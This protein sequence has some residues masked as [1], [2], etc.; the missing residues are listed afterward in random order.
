MAF[1]VRGQIRSR[2]AMLAWDAG[3]LDGDAFAVQQAQDDAAW[4]TGEVVGPVGGPYVTKNYFAEALSAAIFLQEV[5]F[6]RE[7]EL[8]WSGDIPEPPAVPE[9]AVI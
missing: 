1:T 4:Y 2:P 8:T 3:R 6:D 7:P 9:G 5:V